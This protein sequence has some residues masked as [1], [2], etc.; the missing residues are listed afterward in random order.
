VKVLVT[1]AAGLLGAHIAAALAPTEEV[2][3]LDRH[4]WWGDEP[5]RLELGDLTD[6]DALERTVRQFKPDVVFHCAAL[7]NVDAC[8]QS[9]AQAFASNAELPGRLARAVSPG[10]L[11]VYIA[12]DGVFRGED[13]FASEEM[14]PEPRTVYGRSKLA[15]EVEVASATPNHLILR[16]NFFGWSSGRKQTSAE[17]LYGALERQEPITLFDDFYFT[18]IYVVAFASAMLRLIDTGARGL[19]HLAGGERVSK[20]EFGLRLASQAGFSTANVRRGSILSASLAAPRPR[21]M[22]LSTARAAA[23]LGAPLPRADDSI[24]WFLADRG[25][26]LSVRAAA[27]ARGRVRL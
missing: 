7:V 23:V 27:A 4:P 12:T 16:T 11:F 26:P 15:G 14:P 6:G 2:L 17:W 9:T 10:C 18:P 25:K 5:V 8:E 1:G 3:G 24:S 22:S 21:D 20:C 13:P 19:F